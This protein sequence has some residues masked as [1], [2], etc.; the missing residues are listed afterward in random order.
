MRECV[1]ELRV[2]KTFLCVD[3]N[4]KI[5]FGELSL[6]L[7]LGVSGKKLIVPAAT[8]LGALE[9]DVNSKGSLKPSVCIKVKTIEE[10][11]TF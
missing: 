8:T 9:H 1:F 4:A 10:Y 5:D 2:I 7:S 11:D 3:D 6:T